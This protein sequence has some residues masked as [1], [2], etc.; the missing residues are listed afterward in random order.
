MLKYNGSNPS[1][2][3]ISVEFDQQISLIQFCVICT[4]LQTVLVY[5]E[6]WKYAPSLVTNVKAV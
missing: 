4:L 1:L 2:L 3:K 6:V 5:F